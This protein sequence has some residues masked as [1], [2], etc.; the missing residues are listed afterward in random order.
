MSHDLLTAKEAA[1]RLG[2]TV[3]TLYDWLGQSDVGLLVIRGQRV[4]I[5]YFQSGANGQGKIQIESSEIDK[6][7]EL[8]RVVPQRVTPRRHHLHSEQFPGITVPLGRPQHS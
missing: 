4:T 3:T 7:R 8:M 1:R 5:R 2:I 6:L